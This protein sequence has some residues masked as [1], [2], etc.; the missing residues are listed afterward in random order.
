MRKL[1]SAK[2]VFLLTLI[3]LLVFVIHCNKKSAETITTLRRLDALVTQEM[4]PDISAPSAPSSDASSPDTKKTREIAFVHVGKTGGTTAGKLIRKACYRQDGNCKENNFIPQET[5]ISK[6]VKEFFHVRPVNVEKYNSFIVAIRDPI[7]RLVS[8]FYYQHP[9]NELYDSH[10]RAKKL[11][12]CYDKIDDLAAKGLRKQDEDE[13][14]TQE[15]KECMKLAH[16]C[17]AGKLPTYLFSHMTL[18]YQFYVGELLKHEEKEI[19]V[20]RTE[21][22]WNDWQNINTFLGGGPIAKSKSYT[23]QKSEIQPANDKTLSFQGV[24]NLCRVLCHEIQAYRQLIVRAKNLSE[25]EKYDSLME[26]IKKCPSE[27]FLS[28]CDA[29]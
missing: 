2:F 17:V 20:L 26:I 29:V 14:L 12:E 28:S 10:P 7:D 11:F 9:K 27:A 22:F 1:E 15:E 13:V 25:Y 4:S 24:Q 8:W 6:Q 18:N 5:E 19:F 3:P 16:D 21:A 23:H